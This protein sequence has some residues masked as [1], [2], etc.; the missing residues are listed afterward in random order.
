MTGTDTGCGVAHSGER[1][2]NLL[3]GK[4][5][6]QKFLAGLCDVVKLE[7]GVRGKVLQ[8]LDERIGFPGTSQKV[9]HGNLHIL[10]FAAGFNGIH[11]KPGQSHADAADGFDSRL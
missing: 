7:R 10:K 6:C 9:R 5:E 1:R 11:T 8:F 4:S 3:G 2:D